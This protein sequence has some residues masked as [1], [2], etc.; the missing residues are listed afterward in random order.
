MCIRD[1][2]EEDWLKSQKKSDT[3]DIFEDILN[4]RNIGSGNGYGPPNPIET[5]PE[6]S[7]RHLLKERAKILATSE[8][9]TTPNTPYNPSEAAKSDSDLQ[10]QEKEAWEDIVEDLKGGGQG[11]NQQGSDQG[12]QS[13]QGGQGSADKVADAGQSGG[14]PSGQSSGGSGEPSSSRTGYKGPTP[15]RGGSS[16]SVADILARIKGLQPR[17]GYGGGTS[18]TGSE[19]GTGSGTGIGEIPNGGFGQGQQQGPLGSGGSSQGQNQQGTGQQGSD[20]QGQGQSPFGQSPFGQG[21]QGQSQQGQGQQGQSA[22]GQS[23]QGQQGQSQQG[24]SPFGQGQTGQGQ[25]GQDQ[26]GQSPLRGGSSTSVA[27]ILAGIKGQGGGISPTGTE[28]GI[29]QLPSGTGQGQ[30]QGLSLIHI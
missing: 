5:L 26:Q 19:T 29:G 8:P 30:I 27:E 16:A 14:S 23:G 3:T 10:E 7:R 17:S 15:L 11:G 12:D 22:Q 28:T 2:S 20:Q 6:E 4:N 21:Q 24:Q 1:R 13:G 9:G 25:Q 18:P